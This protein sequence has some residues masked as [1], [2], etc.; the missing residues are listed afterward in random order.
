M[1]RFTI[2]GISAVVGF[3]ANSL[4]ALP[5][6][7]QS[8]TN[9]LQ[10]FRTRMLNQRLPD[11][12]PPPAIEI[13]RNVSASV[14]GKAQIAE[15]Q[16]LLNRLG[17]S[18]GRVDG[19]MGRKTRNA[20][21]AFQRNTGRAVNGQIDASVLAA[22]RAAGQ[23]A[24]A[25]GQA[26]TAQGQDAGPA[27]DCRAVTRAVE[28]AV[29]GS[30][31]LGALD[32]Q[33]DGV[34]SDALASADAAGAEQ[35]RSAERKWIARRDACGGDVVCIASAYRSRIAALN[36][37]G[38]GVRSPA[39]QQPAGTADIPATR[40][41]AETTNVVQQFGLKTING[42]PVIADQYAAHANI[43]TDRQQ[44]ALVRLFDLARLGLD[45]E[46]ARRGIGGNDVGLCF[47]R[48]FLSKA[49]R[50]RYLRV[51]DNTDMA[52][53]FT[54]GTL[55]WRGS[56]TN[57]FEV[58]RAKQAFANEV[59]PNLVAQAPHFP[60]QFMYVSGA[61]FLDR[62]DDKR[63]GF[64]VNSVDV[65]IVLPRSTC[66]EGIE[67]AGHMPLDV[68]LPT[69]WK[70][71][72][73]RAEREVVP[74]LKPGLGGSR[75]L[76][77]AI[78]IS[79]SPAREMRNRQGNDQQNALTPLRIG[80]TSI[81]LY[82][83]PR[84]TRLVHEFPVRHPHSAVMLSGVPNNFPVPSRQRLDELSVAMLLLGQS[85]D[86]IDRDA[87][88]WL[89][90]RNLQYDKYYYSREALGYV[91]GTL[92]DVKRD[93][94]APDYVP[95]APPGVDPVNGLTD[96]Q[97]ATFKQWML[98]RARALPKQFVQT[99]EFLINR[100]AGDF[101]ARIGL[102]DRSGK[103]IDAL[104]ARGFVPDQL[105]R[106]NFGSYGNDVAFDTRYLSN[107]GKKR[108]PVL[109]LPSLLSNYVPRLSAEDAKRI[110]GN[111]D[112]Q[113]PVDFDFAI[114]STEVVPVDADTEVVAIHILPTR[115][116]FIN[117]T[118]GSVALERT[119][120][121]APLARGQTKAQNAGA[122]IK[123][124]GHKLRLTAETADLLIARFL[125]DALDDKMLERMLLSRWYYEAEYKG[126]RQEPDWGRFFL[127]GAAKPG[128]GR[129][130]VLLA[131]FKDWTLRRA[132]AMPDVVTMLLPNATAS[133]TG[134]IRLQTGST[135]QDGVY[136]SL[137]ISECKSRARTAMSKDPVIGQP[138]ATAC[139]LVEKAA[140]EP[141]RTI[142]YGYVSTW[143]RDLA[144]GDM[145]NIYKGEDGVG[146]RADC[147]LGD[148][149][150]HL[151]H[152]QVLNGDMLGQPNNLNDVVVFDKDIAVP[153]NRPD[154]LKS[155]FSR[156]IAV[157]VKIT[158]VHL[159]DHLPADQFDDIKRRFNARAQ[160]AGWNYQFK[161][162]AA[163]ALKQSI[164][165]FDAEVQ[166]ARFVKDSD[167][168]IIGKL[169]V[170]PPEK[171]DTSVLSA[172][173]AA[174]SPAP[175][176]ASPQ[177]EPF[178]PD[179]L[180]IQLGMSFDQADKII[181][182]HMKVAR[183]LQADRAWQTGAASGKI[184]TYTSG[185]LY[186]TEEEKEK[187]I[188]FDEPPAAK[189]IILGIVRQIALPADQYSPAD[190][191]GQVQGKYGAPTATDEYQQFW[192]LSAEAAKD[193]EC[194]PGFNTKTDFTLWRL[195]D[196]KEPDLGKTNGPVDVAAIVNAGMPQRSD[197]GSD[198]AYYDAV[199]K[200]TSTYEQRIIEEQN[201][202]TK[203][204]QSYVK[205]MQ[206][207][208]FFGMGLYETDA[209]YTERCRTGLSASFITQG[210]NSDFLVLRAFDHRLYGKVFRASVRKLKSGE[211]YVVPSVQTEGRKLGIKF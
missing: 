154:L 15:A 182:K 155:D 109:V 93:D 116:R 38:E 146:P 62:Y 189:G 33:L 207:R 69:F 142:Y 39:V 48:N 134:P 181:R 149:Y 106:P 49:R 121:V 130:K 140:N 188:L 197:F 83:D 159:D 138:F 57:E 122:A 81:A 139:N 158:G 43:L 169:D 211:R 18:A 42:L 40:L 72:P 37:A 36:S 29:C 95:F 177:I 195:P 126:E 171:L 152:R 76:Y 127:R 180:G 108:L 137:A 192:E 47:A 147:Q 119:F 28:S 205:R 41:T 141:S 67:S 128:A 184:S 135:S 74:V 4:V 178:G 2:L 32:R 202:I 203:R 64:P 190:I 193:Y 63:G 145:S 102:S 77:M 174:A 17:Y 24:I 150:C 98:A 168:Q 105:L 78:G 21:M 183:M 200:F 80:V 172:P 54:P 88:E 65:R 206:D 89:A 132:A 26:A 27:F 143:L 84:L 153:D 161:D 73:Q 59:L 44:A 91:D 144:N 79:V 34:Y 210:H 71:D 5:T 114:E 52:R 201:K 104:V 19:E 163:Q 176:V 6:S 113:Y 31:E 92:K 22:L 86:V 208:T 7:A 82:A 170:R 110:Y 124:P 103:D 56:G 123:V 13:G 191:Y 107:R 55:L 186:E 129:R 204:S 94:Y 66:M 53:G 35:L 20:I 70:I 45:P 85:G 179:I 87:W 3:L 100:K 133:E 164:H 9:D 90:R 101:D 165:V 131:D 196:G 58:Q 10:R 194:V 173:E 120:N 97:L 11:R 96:Q 68:E 51:T 162:A 30:P 60:L 156:N 167:G 151:M 115:L 111:S 61:V 185:R 14:V 160:K 157:D 50:D 187:I 46:L 198:Q 8:T 1:S 175:S 118:D 209:N 199:T 166:A 117:T 99:G 125:P 136:E 75:R 12:S 16:Q 148:D 23:A 25:A 112:W